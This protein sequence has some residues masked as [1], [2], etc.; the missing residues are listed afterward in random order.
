MPSEPWSVTGGVSK[1]AW[2]AAGGRGP[3]A[4]G[5]R[6]GS[7]GHGGCPLQGWRS[8]RS[9]VATTSLASGVAHTAEGGLPDGETFDHAG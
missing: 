8:G 9:E 1:V 6:A 7:H 2:P 3:V 4:G 5:A